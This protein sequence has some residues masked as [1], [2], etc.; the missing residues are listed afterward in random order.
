MR[1]LSQ[2]QVRRSAASRALIDLVA[3]VAWAE[4]RHAGP[5]QLQRVRDEA[6]T[7]LPE[8]QRGDA[9]AWRRAVELI[10]TG[11]S[12]TPARTRT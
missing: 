9:E 4:R 7:L 3:E 11:R 6:M 2:A 5:A 8:V 12:T 1:E 10:G